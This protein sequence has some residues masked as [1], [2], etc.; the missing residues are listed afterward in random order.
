LFFNIQGK[1]PEMKQTQSAV[2]T[3]PSAAS[4]GR[5]RREKSEITDIRR[6][7]FAFWELPSEEDPIVDILM[8]GTWEALRERLLAE[9]GPR[10]V[11]A[12]LMNGQRPTEDPHHPQP[13]G[14]P[15]AGRIWNHLLGFDLQAK[16]P[17]GS[18]L[19]GESDEEG[20]DEED[21]VRGPGRPRGGWPPF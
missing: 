2:P 17:S 21:E 11:T 6:F 4:L 1:T 15:P 10:N 8:P 5:D 20:E 19:I 12:V 3:N 13:R 7:C 18:L 14:R 9:A 16:V